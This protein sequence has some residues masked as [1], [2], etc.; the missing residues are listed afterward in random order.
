MTPDNTSASL[1]LKRHRVGMDSVRTNVDP[2]SLGM[3]VKF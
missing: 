3:A 1:N 2:S